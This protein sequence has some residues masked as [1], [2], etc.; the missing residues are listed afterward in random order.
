MVCWD[1]GFSFFL[2]FFFTLSVF[3][4]VETKWLV[5][6]LKP[7][8]Y[9]DFCGDKMGCLATWPSSSLKGGITFCFFDIICMK[10]SHIDCRRYLGHRDV[11]KA[12]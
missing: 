9:F 1:D 6:M 2:S 5:R 7:F 3:E 8:G 12:E 4:V 11:G 10:G